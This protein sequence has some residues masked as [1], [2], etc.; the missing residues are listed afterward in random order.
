MLVLLGASTET[1]AEKQ[2]E[3]HESKAAALGVATAA[4][5]EE[6]ELARN[7]VVRAEAAK[8]RLLSERNVAAAID[9]SKK[10]AEAM[11]EIEGKIL[12]AQ[13]AVNA[14]L[15]KQNSTRERGLDLAQQQLD[16]ERERQREEAKGKRDAIEIVKAEAVAAFTG[17]RDE[18]GDVPIEAIQGA[19][20]IVIE[21][22]GSE[23][24]A[25][26]VVEEIISGTFKP[27]PKKGGSKKPKK[28]EKIEARF[29][30]YRDVLKAYADSRAGVDAKA[31][32]SLAKGM[33][34]KDHRPETSITVTNNNNYEF[35][36]QIVIDGVGR[37]NPAV[38]QDIAAHFKAEV[39]KAL[40]QTPN[41]LVR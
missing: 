12:D 16:L 21:A 33:M 39:E 7:E 10:K 8:N 23:A 15:A 36:S 14:A 25:D 22:G 6:K 5:R 19:R 34:P 38:A 27:T 29:G 28:E 18:R 9:D 1:I 3:I 32:D 30:D 13:D 11:H 31:L 35:E 40:R 26:Q 20:D 37:S 41:G 17:A 4:I 24:D 2:A